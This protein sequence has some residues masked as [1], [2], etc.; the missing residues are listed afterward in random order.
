MLG[1][2]EEEVQAVRRVI[3]RGNFF[4]YEVHGQ[5]ERFERRWAAYL[6]R[7]SPSFAFKRR[8][9]ITFSALFLFLCCDRSSAQCTIIPEGLCRIC[10]A[11]S[12]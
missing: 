8:A 4:R 7:S 11:E 10:T 3:K 1:I 6:A 9:R 5:C 12:T 2:G